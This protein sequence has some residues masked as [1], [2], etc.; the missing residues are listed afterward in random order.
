MREG[1]DNWDLVDMSASQ[2]AGSYL[3][4]KPELKK[5]WLYEKLI[6]S[7]RLWDRRIAIVS[8]QHFINKGECEDT[9]KLSEILLDDKEDLIHKATGWTLREMGK[10]FFLRQSSRRSP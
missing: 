7:G 10:F 5:T 3:I 1:I 2:V 8:T 9:I 4:N 6:T